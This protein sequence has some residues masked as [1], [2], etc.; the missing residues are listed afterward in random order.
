VTSRPVIETDLDNHYRYVFI[1]TGRLLDTSDVVTTA[2]TRKQA[3]YA[4]RDGNNVR[5]NRRTDPG[6][7]FPITPA[8]LS[9]VTDPLVGATGFPAIGW[10]LNQDYVDG[11]GW[12]SISRPNASYAPLVLFT[13]ILMTNADVCKPSGQSRIYGLR[14]STGQ[15]MLYD[16]DP[17]GSNGS[18]AQRQRYMDVTGIVIGIQILNERPGPNDPAGSRTGARGTFHTSTGGSGGLEFDKGAGKGLRRMNWREIPVA[19]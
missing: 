9:Q 15:S 2:A 1:N 7:T 13:S 10:Y 6:V 18:N 3:F 19:D 4:L 14:F 16:I 8:M 11:L 17:N 5:F 12:R